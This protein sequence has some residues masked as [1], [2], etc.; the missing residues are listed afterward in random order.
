MEGEREVR[1]RGQLEKSGEGHR[2]AADALQQVWGRKGEQ[3]S[4]LEMPVRMDGSTPGVSGREEGGVTNRRAA[5]ES[6]AEEGAREEGEE[7]GGSVAK[8]E[9]GEDEEEE[10]EWCV[11]D[12]SQVPPHDEI[13][14]KRKETDAMR[15]EDL[16]FSY[17]PPHSVPP[18]HFPTRSNLLLKAVVGFK[19][20]MA[21]V[22]VFSQSRAPA[23][24]PWSIRVELVHP[25]E[26]RQ[27]WVREEVGQYGGAWGETLCSVEIPKTD[28]EQ[29]VHSGMVCI[30][31][32]HY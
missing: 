4:A 31:V 13:V 12:P 5:A 29:F 21:V 9:E 27:P 17:P 11:I 19:G 6:P 10:G 1:G 22:R 14:K 2:Q 30:H 7:E 25:K 26:V 8:R 23:G 20:E 18:R 3:G 15:T 28:L 32:H 24:L 16:P